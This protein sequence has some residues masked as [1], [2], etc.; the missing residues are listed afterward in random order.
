MALM[1]PVMTLMATGLSL[2]IY[3]IG[4]YII[5]GAQPSEKIALFGDMVVFMSYAMMLLMSFM[6]F[7]I[8]FIMLPRAIVS[9]KRIK[10]VLNTQPSIKDGSGNF[11]TTQRGTIELVLNMITLQNMF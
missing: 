1:G 11:T 6:A 5:N 2:A 8:V 3:W 9:Y 4:A 10:E 7:T